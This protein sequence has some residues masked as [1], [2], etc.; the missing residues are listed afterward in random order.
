MTNF[1]YYQYHV[2]PTVIR[3]FFNTFKNWKDLMTGNYDDYSLLKNKD[4]FEECYNWFWCNLNDDDLIEKEFLEYLDKMVD[5]IESGKEK[6]ISLDKD[7]FTRIE[8]LLDPD[9]HEST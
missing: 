7:F 3:Q 9:E 8:N 4:P 2:I 6:L 1:E 5:D